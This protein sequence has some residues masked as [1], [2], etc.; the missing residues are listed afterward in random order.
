MED[1]GGPGYWG[2]Y[3]YQDKINILIMRTEISMRQCFMNSCGWKY[4][5]TWRFNFIIFQV[6]GR[7][8]TKCHHWTG[9]YLTG[10]S[11]HIYLEIK[12]AGWMATT[13]PPGNRRKVCMEDRKERWSDFLL[14]EMFMW[15]ERA[16]GGRKKKIYFQVWGQL[17]G[18]HFW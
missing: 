4:I 10:W 5:P 12:R 6:L 1:Q 15:K 13:Q 9:M 14:T 3:K 11:H 17:K 7:K 2:S 8:R 18:F 16:S